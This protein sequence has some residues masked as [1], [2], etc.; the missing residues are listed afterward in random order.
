MSLYDPIKIEPVVD[1]EELEAQREFRR[2]GRNVL[3]YAFLP[4]CF[5]WAIIIW[6]ILQW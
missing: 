3:A 4:S 2:K 5:L 6:L 1:E